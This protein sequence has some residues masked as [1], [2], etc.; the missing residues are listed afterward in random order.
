[1]SLA[2]V[3][4]TPLLLA[5][6]TLPEWHPRA[7]DGEDCSVWGY[8]VQHR[9][10]VL[11]FDT[12]V[13]TAHELIDQMYSPAVVDLVDALHAVGIDEREVSA[14]ANSHLHF[15]HCG[16]NHRLDVP[17]WLR[18]A[19]LEAASH[20]GFTVP[21]WAEVPAARRRIAIG[22]E[23]VA[24]GITL[25]E[26]PGHTP[27]HQSLVIDHVDHVEVVAG[28]VCW[29][30]AE[31]DAGVTHPDDAHDERWRATAEE[32]LDRLRALKP[33]TVHLAHDRPV[34]TS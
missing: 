8:A 3:S 12:G 33:R 6:L 17:V 27:G 31:F 32:S 13:G 9:D 18:E 24:D 16:Q 29:T 14:I 26:T 4:V 10:G 30:C 7:V 1:M 34:A 22:N 28:Q 11:V 2:R 19:E 25:I 21:E 23:Q 15:D 5:T 20:Q